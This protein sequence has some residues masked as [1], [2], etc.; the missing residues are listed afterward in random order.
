M[1]SP[2]SHVNRNKLESQLLTERIQKKYTQIQNHINPDPPFI[3]HPSTFCIT[4][5]DTPLR[6]KYLFLENNH[7]SNSNK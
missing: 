4:V 7:L 2:R 3:S 5:K 1:L 6:A